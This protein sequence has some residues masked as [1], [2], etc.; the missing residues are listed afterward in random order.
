VPTELATTK[1]LLTLLLKVSDALT[2]AHA[3]GVIH[4]DVKP[5]NIMLGE[6]G[7]VVLVD[8]GEARLRGESRVGKTSQIIGT[9]IYM[10]PEQAQGE[11]ADERS[12]VSCLGA[13]LFHALLLRYP[14]WS[15][16]QEVFW[17]QKRTGLIDPPTAN[18]QTRF[19]RRLLAI[20]SK[21]MA[22]DAGERYQ[23]IVEFANDLT[24]FQAGQ[25]VQAYHET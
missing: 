23:S 13:S 21:S 20:I 1:D 7:E 14:T 25:A 5:D 8:W 18:E 10:S 16:D 9:P 6:H 15:D 2:R 22:V 12:D 24:A 11:R 3:R 4:Q 17:H 19:P